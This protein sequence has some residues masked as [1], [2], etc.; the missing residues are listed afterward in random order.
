MI[1]VSIPEVKKQPAATSSRPATQI[2]RVLAAAN[3]PVTT[4]KV[5]TNRNK[6][7]AKTKSWKLSS[8]SPLS[9][10]RTMYIKYYK[11]KGCKV[12]LEFRMLCC[13]RCANAWEIQSVEFYS[14]QTLI[15]GDN[16]SFKDLGISDNCTLVAMENS[17]SFN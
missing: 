12:G 9:Q 8:D 16:M 4:I 11:N 15:Q 17:K 5:Q 14:N 13:F 1:D 7:S 2:K 6:T 3:G 10:L